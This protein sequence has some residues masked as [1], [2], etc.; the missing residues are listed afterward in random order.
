MEKIPQNE[1]RLSALTKRHDLN[2]FNSTSDELNDFLKND[3][4]DGQN[5]MISRTYLCFYKERLLGFITL[6]GDTIETKLMII[7][8]GID[9]YEYDKYPAIKIGRLAVDKDYEG[10]GIGPHMLKWSIGL[11][12]QISQQIGCRY[13]TVDSKK[14]STWLYEREGFKIVKKQRNRNFPP[15]YLNMYAF[16][17]KMNHAESLDPFQEDE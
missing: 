4:L 8:D 16:H 1:L 7:T 14:D 13:I 6:I 15:M 12:Y 5:S 3:A 9:G 17:Q 2:Y 10:R 11:V